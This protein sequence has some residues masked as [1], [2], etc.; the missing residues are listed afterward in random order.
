MLQSDPAGGRVARTPSGEINWVAH[1]SGLRV[2]VLISESQGQSADGVDLS[3]SGLSLCL[4]RLPAAQFGILRDRPGY[5]PLN[6]LTPTAEMS[7]QKRVI[8]LV[9]YLRPR[10]ARLIKIH[11]EQVSLIYL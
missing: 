7:Y 4:E 8:G 2:G 3:Q 1:T 11:S 6:C 9:S 5:Q 10:S